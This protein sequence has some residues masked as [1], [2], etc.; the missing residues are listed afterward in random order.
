MEATSSPSY[1]QLNKELISQRAKE[2]RLA[3][4]QLELNKV[5]LPTFLAPYLRINPKSISLIVS[6]E[7]QL[8]TLWTL[9][10]QSYSTHVGKDGHLV[11]SP[12][13]PAVH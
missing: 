9:F 4:K 13:H 2:A 1:Y 7:E 10:A 5:K 8:V 12:Q 11:D 3:N 6:N